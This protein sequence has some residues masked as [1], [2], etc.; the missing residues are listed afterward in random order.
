MALC[1]RIQMCRISKLPSSSSIAREVRAE[2]KRHWKSQAYI[3]HY[4]NLHIREYDGSN[5]PIGNIYV[6]TSN[7][8]T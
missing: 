5:W 6:F 8:H 2:N 1:V 4:P 7:P 3:K